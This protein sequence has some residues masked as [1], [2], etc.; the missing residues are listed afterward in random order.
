MGLRRAI[1]AIVVLLLC[2]LFPVDAQDEFRRGDANGDGIVLPLEDA[3]FL[4]LG[5][6]FGPFPPCLDAADV[7]DNGAQ[8]ALLDALYLLNWGFA[9]GDAP[10]D[11]GP[12]EC[13][14]DPTD[15]DLECD[16]TPDCGEVVFDDPID[17]DYTLTA[18]TVDG[19]AIGNFVSLAITLDGPENGDE[20]RGLQWSLCHDDLVALD[21]NG[22]EEGFDFEPIDPTYTSV[23]IHDDGWT[24]G[25]LLNFFTS[26][27]IEDPIGFELYTARYELVQ[28]GESTIEFCAIGDEYQVTPAILSSEL[29]PVETVAATVMISDP[30]FLRGDVD[31]N[32]SVFSLL[33]GLYLLEWGFTAGPEIPCQRAADADD[34]GVVFP[35]LDAIMILGFGF[36]GGAAPPEPFPDC[37]TDPTPD[38]LSCEEI[39]PG[40]E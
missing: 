11:P 33:D 14:I 24:F 22:I 12:F 2:P 18:S 3:N 40:C 39:S 8:F 21:E 9:G 10:P 30:L 5:V 31:G 38:A 26:D 4:L 7:D 15:D 16:T 25:T 36:T 29:I 20:I 19:G 27:F 23:Q 17:S 1:A 32:G 34:D 28:T 35:I 37:G 6:I 13:G